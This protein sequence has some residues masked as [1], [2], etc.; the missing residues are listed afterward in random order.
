MRPG[1]S[2]ERAV[3]LAPTGRDASVAAA[4]IKEAG[5]YANICGDIAGLMHEIEGGAGLAVIADEAIKTADLR[6]LMRWLNEQPSWSDFPV[7]LFTHQGGGPERN[8]DAARLAHA[9]GNVTFIERP[10]H[11]T[12][13]TSVVGWNGRSMNVTLPS[14]CPSRTASGLR[15]GPPP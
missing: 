4:L 11:P 1:A 13:L 12:T 10:F 8:P 9:L 15:S 7:V 14:T 2:S 6:G 3:I 5:F